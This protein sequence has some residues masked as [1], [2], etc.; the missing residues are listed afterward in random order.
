MAEMPKYFDNV[1]IGRFSLTGVPVKVYVDGVYLTI[2]DPD[3]IEDPI[4]GFGNGIKKESIISNAIFDSSWYL[5]LNI[6]L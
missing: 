6:L 3:D 5:Y 4:I 1:T 2:T